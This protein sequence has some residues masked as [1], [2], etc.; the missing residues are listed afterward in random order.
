MGQEVNDENSGGDEEDLAR[1]VK[2]VA[3][4]GG[5]FGGDFGR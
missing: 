3:L 1:G 2:G 5:K 4:V